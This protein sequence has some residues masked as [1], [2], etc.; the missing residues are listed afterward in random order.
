MNNVECQ[1]VN[2]SC[3]LTLTGKLDV[4]E[5]PVLLKAA[6]ESVASGGPVIMHVAGLDRVDASIFQILL[7]LQRDARR[8]GQ[9]LQ[10]IGA[11]PAMQ[12]L[13]YLLGGDQSF[14]KGEA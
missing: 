3:Q 11:G 1:M 2:D 5:A 7:A 13:G 8:Q 10:V 4:F 6:C 14:F 9:S 12:Q